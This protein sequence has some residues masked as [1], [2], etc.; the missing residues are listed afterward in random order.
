MLTADT[1]LH[2]KLSAVFLNI[3]CMNSS[4]QSFDWLFN[5]LINKESI[6]APRENVIAAGGDPTTWFKLNAHDIDAEQYLYTEIP[7]HCV[8][9]P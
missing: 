7:K 5:Y 6:L 2:L 4:T 3:V 9:G 1:S 8:C